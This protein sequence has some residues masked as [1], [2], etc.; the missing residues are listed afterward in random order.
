MDRNSLCSFLASLNAR[1]VSGCSAYGQPVSA[2]VPRYAVRRYG[3]GWYAYTVRTVRGA[4]GASRPAPPVRT[5]RGRPV[6]EACTEA[7][8]RTCQLRSAQAARGN[9]AVHTTGHVAESQYPSVCRAGGRRA[10]GHH[11][12][13]A[14]GSRRQTPFL[15]PSGASRPRQ[16]PRRAT[17]CVIARGTQCCRTPSA[18]RPRRSAA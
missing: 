9:E 2:W 3:R 7:P 10:E 15:S 17:S 16:I 13:S 1:P 18:R 8:G 6:G 4:L 14:R 12:E 11:T 5:Q